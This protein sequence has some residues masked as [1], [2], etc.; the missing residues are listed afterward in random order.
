MAIARA[1]RGAL[2]CTF[3]NTPSSGLW[4][5]VFPAGDCTLNIS[6]LLPVYSVGPSLVV[7]EALGQ[8]IC[9]ARPLARL[10]EDNGPEWEEKGDGQA[11]DGVSY[12]NRM[13]VLDGGLQVEV[14][15]TFCLSISHQVTGKVIKGT[16]G[17]ADLWGLFGTQVA[18]PWPG[19]AARVSPL[20][21]ALLSP[22][23]LACKSRTKPTQ[24]AV[25]QIWATG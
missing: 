25:I 8:A 13:C 17:N 5:P 10:R 3:L 24:N 21:A 6:L 2:G 16:V 15:G 4:G 22:Q 9:A 23:A 18:G 19:T 20:P 7:F 11:L 14:L 12:L 1:E